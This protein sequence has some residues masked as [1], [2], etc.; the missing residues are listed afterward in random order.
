MVDLLTIQAQLALEVDSVRRDLCEME[1]HRCT[2]LGVESVF[3]TLSAECQR[4]EKLPE[5]GHKSRA[6]DEYTVRCGTPSEEIP[7]PS[8]W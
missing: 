4:D 1:R 3:H 8:A 2:L 6:R 7:F 5:G